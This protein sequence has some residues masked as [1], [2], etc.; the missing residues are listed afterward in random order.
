MHVHRYACGERVAKETE[1]AAYSC[2]WPSLEQ[3]CIKRWM[4]FI[5]AY[6]INIP[7]YIVIELHAWKVG[8]INIDKSTMGKSLHYWNNSV[9]ISTLFSGTGNMTPAKPF[10]M[11]HCPIVT[12]SKNS[13]WDR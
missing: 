4:M 10:F 3:F 12:P 11:W 9:K 7:D 8:R 6:K 5:L 1:E 2:Q 13:A